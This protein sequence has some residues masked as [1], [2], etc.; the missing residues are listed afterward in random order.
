M[1]GTIRLRREAVAPLRA[2]ISPL[3]AVILAGCGGPEAKPVAAPPATA[4]AQADPDDVPITEADV[5]RPAGYGEALARIEG[6]RDTI[7]DEIAA[8]RPTKAHRAL[9]ELD[10]VLNWLPAI[11]RDS[12]VPKDRWEAVNT[13]A[14]QVRDLFNQVHSRI[15]AGQAPNFAAIG[16]DVEKSIAELRSES[17]APAGPGEAGNP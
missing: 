11:A 2:L 10:I 13:T 3:V 5:Q 14:Q 12:G 6:Y 1:S 17:P 16:D 9:D 8:G 4:P 15:D 7:R